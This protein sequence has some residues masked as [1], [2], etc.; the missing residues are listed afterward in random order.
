MALGFIALRMRQ[1][2]RRIG[3]YIGLPAKRLPDDGGIGCELRFGQRATGG[4]RAGA[5]P[6]LGT[7][8]ERIAARR[9]ADGS[10]RG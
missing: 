6:I 3:R 8:P 5:V 1:C 10:G 4:G 9:A 7:E 2:P